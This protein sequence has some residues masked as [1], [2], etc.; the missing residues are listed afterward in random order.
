MIIQVKMPDMEWAESHALFD[1]I[2]IYT[3]LEIER[4]D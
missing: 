4:V 3:G 1:D 2:A